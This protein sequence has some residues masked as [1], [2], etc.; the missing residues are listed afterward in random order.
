LPTR[1]VPNPDGSV[2][3]RFQAPTGSTNQ[4]FSADA[5]AESPALMN[6]ILAGQVVATNAWSDWVDVGDPWRKPPGEVAE[7]YYR[8]VKLEQ[9][10]T[11]TTK[12]DTTERVPPSGLDLIGEI[13][14]LI[15][16]SDTNALASLLA[17]AEL[18][19]QELYELGEREAGALNCASAKVFF[20]TIIGPKAGVATEYQRAKAHI[21]LGECF[22]RENDFARA[23]P[24][25]VACSDLVPETDLA[26]EAEIAA[27]QACGKLGQRETERAHFDKMLAW[28]AIPKYRDYARWLKAQS[29]FAEGKVAECAA[30]LRALQADG[31]ANYPMLADVWLK[32]AC[33]P[34]LAEKET[35]HEVR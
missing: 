35:T 5:A 25:F 1:V 16:A 23:L 7:R 32:Q 8:V 15:A 27:G 34:K 30:D 14:S 11:E 9:E 10:I 4:I 20:A 17:A 31:S 22:W 2:T 13:G 19:V 28:P 26:M 12:T 18:S 6:W 3:V 29:Y 21:R 24:Q 33:A